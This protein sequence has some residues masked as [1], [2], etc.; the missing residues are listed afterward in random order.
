MISSSNSA[1]ALA[2]RMAQLDLELPGS[3]VALMGAASAA[4]ARSLPGARGSAPR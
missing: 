1:R 4:A 2:A 3:R